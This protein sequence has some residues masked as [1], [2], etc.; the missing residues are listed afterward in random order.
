[1]SFLYL[2]ANVG[3][4]DLSFCASRLL[5]AVVS[6]PKHSVKTNGDSKELSKSTPPQINFENSPLLPSS[7]AAACSARQHPLAQ[8]DFTSDFGCLPLQSY[9]LSADAVGSG[10]ERGAYTSRKAAAPLLLCCHRP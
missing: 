1:M 7:P 2:R 5:R 9:Q 10:K 3:P 6:C 4:Y 8:K